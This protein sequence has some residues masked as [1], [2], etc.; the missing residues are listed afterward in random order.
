MNIYLPIAEMSMNIFNLIGLGGIVGFLSGLL[1]VS[2]GFLLTPSLI[3]MGIPSS[4]AVASQSANV[5]ATS[6]TGSMTHIKKNNVDY[7]MAFIVL[8]GGIIGSSVG[9]WVFTILNESSQLDLT[10]IILYMRLAMER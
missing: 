8:F 9:V 4:I 2:G 1:G 6:T 10:E 3:L 5:I 7:K